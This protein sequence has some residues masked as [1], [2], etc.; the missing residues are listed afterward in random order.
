MQGLP[1]LHNLR[2]G[3]DVG[4]GFR[5]V[6]RNDDGARESPNARSG[7]RSGEPVLGFDIPRIKGAGNPGEARMKK[8]IEELKTSYSTLARDWRRGVHINLSGKQSSYGGRKVG[9]KE[10]IVEEHKKQNDR[11]DAARRPIEVLKGSSSEGAVPRVPAYLS[12][13]PVYKPCDSS[14]TSQIRNQSAEQLKNDLRKESTALASIITSKWELV[15]ESHWNELQE[16]MLAVERIVDAVDKRLQI[17][18]DDEQ[19]KSVLAK[20]INTLQQLLDYPDQTDMLDKMVDLVRSFAKEPFIGN[21]QFLNIMIMGDAGTGKT[22]L[23]EV[24]GSAMA[25]LGLYVF[26][27]LVEVTA[28]D[29]QGQYI[30]QTRPKVRKFFNDNIEKVIFL[31]EA[32]SLTEWDNPVGPNRTKLVGYSPEAV[33]EIIALTAKQIGRFALIVAGYEANMINDFLPANPGFSRRFP[34][35]ATLGDYKPEVLYKVFIEGLARGF[36]GPRPS[37]EPQRAQWEDRLQSKIQ[38]CYR[39]FTK[40]A[41][42]MFQ[43]VVEASRKQKLVTR[44][45]PTAGSAANTSLLV[46]EP[47]YPLLETMFK[48][49]AGAMVNLAGVAGLL[50]ISNDAF[51]LV[52]HASEGSELVYIDRREIGDRG[53]DW[54]GW[55]NKDGVPASPPAPGVVGDPETLGDEGV[56]TLPNMVADRCA[57]FDILLT[58]MQQ[59]FTKQITV[60]DPGTGTITKEGEFHIAR[61]E[62]CEALSTEEHQWMESEGSDYKWL[63]SRLE[64][65]QKVPGCCT[66]TTRVE[67]SSLQLLPDTDFVGAP[68]VRFQAGGSVAARRPAARPP[69]RVSKRA[70]RPSNP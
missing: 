19:W 37:A 31:D 15:D 9:I 59:T 69:P 8:L 33:D 23:G 35:R 21:Q 43:D 64:E 42:L 46:Y 65:G 25:Q 52:D 56:Q 67:A 32:Y 49:Q 17:V 10:K 66:V 55:K 51:A 61:R 2:L 48:A 58:A 24:L 68:A 5:L 70:R 28:A 13:Y 62:M 12:R 47:V 30:G 14:D 60:R 26:D 20:F 18:T 57:M 63:K 54:T 39:W 29:L 4:V 16:E 50:F 27:E 1:S 22:R 41:V 11:V 40:S 53:A 3:D 34:I 6:P 44:K 36:V 7:E 45:V 38:T